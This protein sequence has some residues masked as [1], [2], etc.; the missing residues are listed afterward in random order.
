MKQIVFIILTFFLASSCSTLKVTSDFDSTTDFSGYKTY[1]YLGW[2]DDSEKILNRFDKERIEKAF[3]EE[4]GKRGMSYVEEGGDIMVSLFIV[5]D[6][7]TATTA[8]TDYY[9]GYGGYRYSMPWGWG[10]GYSTTR[11]HEYDYL[12]G[13]LVCDVFDSKEKALIWQGVGAGTVNE[14]PQK[15]ERNIPLAV[16]KIMAQYPVKPVKN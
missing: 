4:F 2:S 15:R 10:G 6:Q 16:A 7:K 3:A 5:V 8:Y 13:T 1:S 14:D 9:G 11:Y 12:F